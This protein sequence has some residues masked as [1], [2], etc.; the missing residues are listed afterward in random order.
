MLFA[1]TLL[2]DATGSSHRT[3][4]A[5]INASH[6][7]SNLTADEQP[8]SRVIGNES[9]CRNSSNVVCS[10]F[11]SENRTKCICDGKYDHLTCYYGDGTF[12]CTSAD[13]D[14]YCSSP[15]DCP[16]TSPR[17]Y[18]CGTDFELKGD[19][20]AL[21]IVRTDEGACDGKIVCEK[22][23]CSNVICDCDT[24]ISTRC[25]C[26]GDEN[27]RCDYGNGKFGC[28]YKNKFS[29]MHCA[30]STVVCPETSR[31][32]KVCRVDDGHSFW[33]KVFRKMGGP[34]GRRLI[35]CDGDKPWLSSTGAKILNI[36]QL[37]NKSLEFATELRAG[38]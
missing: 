14:M 29:E 9:A 4:A 3:V 13:E 18:V 27:V 23:D 19:R 25:N 11:S 30:P 17:A 38:T 28:R 2:T 26:S 35:R 7:L 10:C 8:R 12:R 6:V 16:K 31:R 36:S 33:L 21:E 5:S 34:C 15:L 20:I 37:G 1:G 32:A 24:G 22:M